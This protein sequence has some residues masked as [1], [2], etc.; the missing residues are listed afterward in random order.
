MP[1]TIS[2]NEDGTVDIVSGGAYLRFNYSS[3]QMRFRYYKS[4]TYAS[5]QP[6]TLYKLGGGLEQ[7]ATPT[8]AP[9]P[10]M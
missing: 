3:N 1:N 7:V 9:P 6:I 2:L 5:Q 10:A 4:A 8:G